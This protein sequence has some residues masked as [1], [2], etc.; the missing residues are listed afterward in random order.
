[1]NARVDVL[2]ESETLLLELIRRARDA[3]DIAA[4]RFIAVNDS[5]LLA[6]YR[7][8]AL[9]FAGEGVQALSG[10]IQ[11]ERNAPYVQWLQDVAR[12][13]Q[14]R[15]AGRVL[16]EDLPQS[17]SAAWGEWLPPYA[18]W[19]PLSAPPAS[20]M[21]PGGLLFAR[22]EAWEDEELAALAEWAATWN[23]LYQAQATPQYRLGWRAR[24]QDAKAHLKRRRWLWA[25]AALLVLCAPVPLTVLAPGELVPADPII[26]RAPLDGVVSKF[27]VRPNQAVKKGERLFSFDDIALGSRYDVAAQALATAEAELRQFEQQAMSDPKART[28]LPAARGALVEKRAELD[29]LR[30]QRGRSEVVAPQ[31]GTVLFDDPSEWIGKPVTTGERILRLAATD[32]REIEA[33]PGVG[34]AIPLPDGA[35]ARLYLS[36]SPLDPVSGS[37]RYV[38]HDAQRRPDGVYAYRV[39]AKLEGTTSHRVGLKGTVRLTGGWTPLAYWLVRRPWAT[40]REFLGL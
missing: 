17:V 22:D 1:M 31:D 11:P 35:S 30:S 24:L 14:A 18:L 4:L 21:P 27:H 10:V 38:S 20:G 32:D 13:L 33:W 5:H 16:A 28:Q 9:W 8:A 19:I 15:P 39:R 29:L 25:G 26:V 37:V 23:R 36:A 40:I 34:D 7:Q 2:P 6:P 12:A 3:E